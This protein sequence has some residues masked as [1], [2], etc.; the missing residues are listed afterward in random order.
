MAHASTGGIGVAA[1]AAPHPP[2]ARRAAIA[3]GR[4]VAEEESALMAR[5]STG[6][7]GRGVA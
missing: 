6:G 3:F 2:R 1:W 5:V 7:V 4:A